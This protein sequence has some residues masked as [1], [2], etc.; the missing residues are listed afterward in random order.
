MLCFL[1]QQELA[2]GSKTTF[3]D[4]SIALQKSRPNATD[5]AERSHPA[6]PLLFPRS[7]PLL[8]TPQAASHPLQGSGPSSA[9]TPPPIPKAP[10]QCALEPVS[11]LP[12]PPVSDD[13]PLTR[14]GIKNE[15]QSLPAQNW[16]RALANFQMLGSLVK[17][18]GLKS[19]EQRPLWDARIKD[20]SAVP[21]LFMAITK[22]QT[23]RFLY[24]AREPH[25]DS[26][27]SWCFVPA[28]VSSSPL[29]SLL[30]SAGSQQV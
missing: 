15:L 20:L 13:V 2:S 8:L 29:H 1:P 21:R 4:P 27:T 22:V 12:Q 5:P 9:R 3:T 10:P 17:L 19:P 30:Q 23:W 25:Q 24:G 16:M 7:R 28:D 18:G 26:W 14:D 11:Y 6:V